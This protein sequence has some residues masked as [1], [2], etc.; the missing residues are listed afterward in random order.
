[1]EAFVRPRGL[2]REATPLVVG[3]IEELTAEGAV[4]HRPTEWQLLPVRAILAGYIYAKA[5]RW[6][7]AHRFAKESASGQRIR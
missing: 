3:A 2:E 7:V 6:K 4:D 1:M 5:L